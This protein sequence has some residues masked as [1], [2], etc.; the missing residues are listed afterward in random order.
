MEE[1]GDPRI[2]FGAMLTI[3][4]LFL[5]WVNNPILPHPVPAKDSSP[6]NFSYRPIS[7]IPSEIFPV[8]VL[9]KPPSDWKALGGS[10]FI[11]RVLQCF[12]STWMLAVNT[13]SFRLPLIHPA[14]TL[15]Q[16]VREIQIW[17]EYKYRHKCRMQMHKRHKYIYILLQFVFDP[18]CLQP[19]TACQLYILCSLNNAFQ[20][21]IPVVAY[22]AICNI[23]MSLQYGNHNIPAGDHLPSRGEQ[24]H[25]E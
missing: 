10:V 3:W 13:T 23:P 20:N 15:Q 18:T 1:F 7:R 11:N 24:H 5:R 4:G 19:S 25:Y 21:C 8:S 17:Y 14:T 16:L 22:C 12:V 9:F 2:N 6:W